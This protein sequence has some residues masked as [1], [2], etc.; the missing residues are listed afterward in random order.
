MPAYATIALV[1]ANQLYEH[2]IQVGGLMGDYETVFF[3]KLEV[4]PFFGVKEVAVIEEGLFLSEFDAEV[5]PALGG[6]GVNTG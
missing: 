2:G 1:K 6:R 4:S 5:E 3:K